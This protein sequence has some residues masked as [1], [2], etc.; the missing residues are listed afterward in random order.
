MPDHCPDRAQLLVEVEQLEEQYSD[1]LANSKC[2][3]VTIDQAEAECER[4]RDELCEMERD[5][6]RHRAARP[7]ADGI[8]AGL[9]TD[10]ER[11]TRERDHRDDLLTELLGHYRD[12]WQEATR[13]KRERTEA[14]RYC[15]DLKRVVRVAREWADY[16]SHAVCTYTQRLLQALYALDQPPEPSSH[17]ADANSTREGERG[18]AEPR[19]WQSA[20]AGGQARDAGMVDAVTCRHCG[21]RQ[22]LAAGDVPGDRCPG[23]GR[24]DAAQPEPAAEQDGETP[25]RC[26]G[27]RAFASFRDDG[28]YYCVFCGWNSDQPE[29]DGEPP[30]CLHIDGMRF[31]GNRDSNFVGTYDWVRVTCRECRAALRRALPRHV[32]QDDSWNCTC[33]DCARYPGAPYRR[34]IAAARTVCDELPAAGTP[35]A[36]LAKCVAAADVDFDARAAR[37]EQDG[38]P[39]EQAGERC[40][41]AR[42]CVDDE[43]VV[44]CAHKAFRERA[45]LPECDGHVADCPD[46]QPRPLANSVA[47]T[48]A[49][50]KAGLPREKEQL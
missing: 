44:V 50:G 17:S 4:L 19:W 32:Y 10:L 40:A 2:Q 42:E 26:P 35:L 8:I 15:A 36:E 25:K 39:A 13:Y 48:G 27:C 43:T 37:R 5:R 16:G 30:T 1:A 29:Q 28:V 47:T 41:N 18:G 34:L 12:Q 38:E 9:R 21:Y 6:N 23:C 11:V 49:D 7:A 31:C 20:D 14:R 22:E 33:A 3:A 46:Y 45:P 24:G